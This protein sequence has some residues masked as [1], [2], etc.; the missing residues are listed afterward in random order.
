MKPHIYIKTYT[1]ESYVRLHAA[2]CAGV[3]S[4][5][6]RSISK[7]SRALRLYL[8]SEA[9]WKALHIFSTSRNL[10]VACQIHPNETDVSGVF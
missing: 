1:F 7:G 9:Y 8:T 5:S 2:C 6:N 3:G 4:M 10:I